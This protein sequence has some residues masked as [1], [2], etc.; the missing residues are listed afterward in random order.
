MKKW[1]L[2]LKIYKNYIGTTNLSRIFK[3]ILHKQRTGGILQEKDAQIQYWLFS[4][5]YTLNNDGI[6]FDSI[7]TLFP[8]TLHIVTLSF[9]FMY[10]HSST[11]FR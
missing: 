9:H 4:V 1:L 2:H 11:R 7:L 8:H 5:Y 10:L 6:V 3:K